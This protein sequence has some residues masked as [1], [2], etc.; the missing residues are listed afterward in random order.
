MS[1]DFG[2]NGYTSLKFLKAT[3]LTLSNFRQLQ[4]SPK[5]RKVKMKVCI[6]G[7]T[8]KI[9]LPYM[10]KY[11]SFFDRNNVEYDIV[12]WQREEDNP[13]EKENEFYYH[14]KPK[15][16]SFHML[17]SYL[18]YKKF[19]VDILKKNKYDKIVVLTTLPAV[20]L[21]KHLIKNYDNKYIFD[22]RNYSFEGFGLFR[23][24]IN[25]II[26]HS[27]MTAVSSMGFLD[28]LDESDKIVLN[29][30]NS[31]I[32]DKQEAQD[33]KSKQVINIGFVGGIKNFDENA[34]LM[35][36]LKNT[37]R[38][39][40]WYIGRPKKNCDLQGYAIENEIT[41]T[42]FIGKFDNSQRLELYDKID[43]VNGIYGDNSLK[44]TTSVPARLY[45]GAL[46]AKPIIASKRTYLGEIVDKYRLGLVF[47]VENE[48]ALTLINNYVDAFNPEEFDQNCKVFLQEVDEEEAVLLNRLNEFVKN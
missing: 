8:E 32:S 37:F 26:R 22:Y 6:I 23:N 28:F 5:E 42:S 44:A 27:N 48:D 3:L 18:R 7:N 15:E 40:L 25:R 21:E 35:Q 43:L 33:L 11:T 13:P 14:E 4:I 30:N 36:K 47:D 31:H 19:V 45:E 17:R 9:Y 12:C 2:Y 38:Y 1:S 41:N 34:V 24:K 10:D 29:H 39:Q 20:M 46:L 16:G